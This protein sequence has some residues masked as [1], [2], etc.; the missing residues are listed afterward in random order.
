MSKGIQDSDDESI[1]EYL[2]QRYGTPGYTAPE[3]LRSDF[4]DFKIDVFS[5]G[6]VLFFTVTGKI[7]FESKDVDDLIEENRICYIDYS[8][9]YFSEEGL[10]F[11]Q[12]ILNPNYSERL[13][14]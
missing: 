10:S 3:I 6:I 7:P 5:L 13:T 12:S 11:I 1:P 14:A 8:K 2:N 9:L 4:Y